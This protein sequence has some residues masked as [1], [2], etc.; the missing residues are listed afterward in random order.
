[1]KEITTDDLKKMPDEERLPFVMEALE[2][3]PMIPVN[4]LIDLELGGNSSWMLVLKDKNNS[5]RLV[6]PP[7]RVTFGEVI[8][9][10]RAVAD[11]IEVMAKQKMKGT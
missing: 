7:G 9:N 8:H 6:V 2:D 11:A 3:L 5:P 1:M 4:G 10:L